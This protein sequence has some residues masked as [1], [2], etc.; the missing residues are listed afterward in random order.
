MQI[1]S[2]DPRCSPDGLQE[3][4]PPRSFCVGLQGAEQLSWAQ[5][6]EEFIVGMAEVHQWLA[7]LGPAQLAVT[8]LEVR[9]LSTD[10]TFS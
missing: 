10:G 2:L 5:K 7:G 4:G 3:E 9:E 8:R 1:L 6:R